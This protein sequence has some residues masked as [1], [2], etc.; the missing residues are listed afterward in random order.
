MFPSELHF[1]LSL[2]LALREHQQMRRM[3]RAFPQPSSWLSCLH[4]DSQ[5]SES[6]RPDP[7][8]PRR[9]EGL[10]RNTEWADGPLPDQ[11]K[12]PAAHLHIVSDSLLEIVIFVC[13]TLRPL[14]WL[15]ASNALYI[16]NCLQHQLN[17]TSLDPPINVPRQ[18]G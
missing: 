11:W 3:T 13:Q 5:G 18:M 9:T 15:H 8:L 12:Y 17:T 16:D 2:T 1:L 10:E 7:F 4:K 14:I 6:S